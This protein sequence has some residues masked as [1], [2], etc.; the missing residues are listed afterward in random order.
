MLEAPRLHSFDVFSVISCAEHQYL[1]TV[2]IN[3]LLIKNRNDVSIMASN[4]AWAE[5]QIL[6][7]GTPSRYDL[8]ERF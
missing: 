4:Y 5:L 1:F 3:K 6:D 7:S 8:D 2:S